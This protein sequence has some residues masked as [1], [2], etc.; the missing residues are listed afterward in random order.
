MNARDTIR[1]R[2]AEL[3]R[4]FIVQLSA[5][6]HYQARRLAEEL[7]MSIDL[8]HAEE[9]AKENAP[10]PPAGDPRNTIR[11]RTAG[12]MWR[13]LAELSALRTGPLSAMVEYPPVRR[14]AEDLVTSINAMH[15]DE[16]ANGNAP[17]PPSGHPSQ[18]PGVP[19]TWVW[20]PEAEDKGTP[21]QP[22][23]MGSEAAR[24]AATNAAQM[25]MAPAF[26]Q[27]FPRAVLAVVLDHHDLPTYSKV[28]ILP[29]PETQ[30]TAQPA[31]CV[32]SPWTTDPTA[33]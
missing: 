1:Y 21:E 18:T 8:L 23:Y 30:Q 20:T 33:R 6:D 31:R 12:R 32:V 25:V 27:L 11:N 13:F 26:R 17:S 22:R 29:A 24:L 5:L 2:T 9:K 16:K 3:V 19:G 28:I 4:R 7:A 15:T 10:S 14:L